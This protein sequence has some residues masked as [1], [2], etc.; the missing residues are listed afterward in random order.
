[1]RLIDA[2]VVMDAIA[3][4]KTSAVS[5]EYFKGVTECVEKITNAPTVV[6]K[7]L[8]DRPTGEWVLHNKNFKTLQYHT[9]SN[10]GARARTILTNTRLVDNYY[11]HKCEPIT[12]YEFDEELSDFC[13]NCGA[14]MVKIQR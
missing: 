11:C 5:A 8:E 10:C 9:C 13:P 2:D 12:E 3:K 4:Q 1:M 6:I 14:R 7:A